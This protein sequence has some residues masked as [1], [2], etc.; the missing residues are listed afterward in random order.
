MRD[1]SKIC[2]GNLEGR[3]HVGG[4]S[5]DGSIILNGY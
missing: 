1:A 2:T 5:V 4:I 3:D